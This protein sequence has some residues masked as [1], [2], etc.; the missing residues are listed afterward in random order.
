MTTLS[1]TYTEQKANDAQ[2]E[3]RKRTGGPRGRGPELRSDRYY[4]RIA[5]TGTAGSHM[6]LDIEPH[7]SWSNP[8]NLIPAFLLLMLLISAI[9]LLVS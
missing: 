3:L 6:P 4:D 8:L 2:R 1:R 7:W 5:H 9:E